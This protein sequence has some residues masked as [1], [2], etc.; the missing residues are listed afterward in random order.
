M[1]T[2]LMN[3]LTTAQYDN[4]CYKLQSHVYLIWKLLTDI[5]RKTPGGYLSLPFPGRMEAQFP[6]HDSDLFMYFNLMLQ[7]TELL[8]FPLGKPQI[9]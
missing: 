7:V 6:Q 1:C 4:L 3:S 9:T 8:S 5:T 2:L